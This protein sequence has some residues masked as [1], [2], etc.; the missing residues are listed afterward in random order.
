MSQDAPINLKRPL[1][2]KDTYVKTNEEALLQKF[3]RVLSRCCSSVY[4]SGLY[5]MS[6]PVPG[7]N[8]ILA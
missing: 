2:Q 7:R 3:R 6:V 4:L 1:E 8:L 5:S